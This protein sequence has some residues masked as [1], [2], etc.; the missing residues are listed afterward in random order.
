MQKIVLDATLREKLHNL[1]Q[2]LELCDEAGQVLG[3][4]IPCAGLAEFE[5]Y[6]PSFREEDLKRQ[7]QAEEKRFT[8]AEVMAYLEKL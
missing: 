4:V 7:E 1:A 8:F 5:P 3:R 6:E 2:P